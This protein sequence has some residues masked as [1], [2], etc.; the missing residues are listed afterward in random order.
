GFRDAY[1]FYRIHRLPDDPSRYRTERGSGAISKHRETLPARLRRRVVLE[2]ESCEHGILYP[3]WRHHDGVELAMRAVS[4]N[5]AH[6]FEGYLALA[7]AQPGDEPRRALALI[8]DGPFDFNHVYGH[9]DGTIGWELFGRLP[10]RRRDGLFVRDA[11]DPE[12]QWE[13][14]I[15]FEAMPKSL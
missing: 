3:G 13:G 12:A 2:W 8:N 15:P 11:H 10:R 6:Y 4:S 5:L 9:R 7:A 14:W 1:D